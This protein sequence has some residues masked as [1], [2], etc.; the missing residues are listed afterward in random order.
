MYAPNDPSHTLIDYDTAGNQTK[1]YLTGNG[2][3]VFDAENRMLSATTGGVTSSYTYSADGQ[4][5]RRSLTS[6]EVWQVYGLDGELLAEYNA[7]AATFVPQEEYGYRN[8]QLLIT[9][10]APN[11]TNVALASNGATAS[12]SSIL[13]GG[14]RRQRRH[15]RRSQRRELGQRRR[16]GRRFL[17]QLP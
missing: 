7:N 5:V 11:R 12:A 17:R 8:G 2:T 4:R 1:D 13:R 9:A 16:L 6:G 14:L 3:R 15:Q 10:A